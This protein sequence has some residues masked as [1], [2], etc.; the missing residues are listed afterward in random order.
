M[1]SW[2][3]IDGKFEMHLIHQFSSVQRY[4]ALQHLHNPICCIHVVDYE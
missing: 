3:W 4:Y 1:E 2:W